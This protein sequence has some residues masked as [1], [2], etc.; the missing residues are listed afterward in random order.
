MT[1]LGVG[2]ADATETQLYGTR[3]DHQLFA[4]GRLDRFAELVRPGLLVL[5][6]AA[7]RHAAA[8]DRRPGLA[9]ETWL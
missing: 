2:W 9:A 5:L 7:D 4:D 8:R 1:A 3:A 6:P